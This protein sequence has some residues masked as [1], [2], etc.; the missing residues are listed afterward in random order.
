MKIYTELLKTIK[1]TVTNLAKG[2][3]GEQGVVSGWSWNS[4]KPIVDDDVISRKGSSEYKLMIKDPSVGPAVSTK[5]YGVLAK[6]YQIT[7]CAGE[8][9]ANYEQ[10][11]Q[12]ADFVEMIFTK[13]PGTLTD[14]LKEILRDCIQWGG[15]IGE[16][17]W[18]WDKELSFI[19]LTNIKIKDPLL[20]DTEQ[21]DYGNVT[22]LLLTVK[23]GKVEVDQAKFIRVVYNAV[24]GEAWGESDLRG[25][26]LYWV[27]KSKLIRW[28]A[29]YLEKFAMPTAKGSF[30][31]GTPKTA[32]DDLLKVLS[33]IQQETA[34]VIP[35][36]V[37]VELM[38][39][40]GKTSSEF[41]QA[42]DYF[43]KQITKSIL[44]QTLATE[45]N[46]KTGSLAQAKVH[47]DTL[48]SYITDLK[49]MIE[50]VMDEQVIR[51]IVDYNF[52]DRFYPNFILPLDEKDI[53][54][55]AAI[56]YQLTTCGQVNIGE[57][58]IREFLG[59]PEMEDGSEVQ[60][61][62]VNPQDTKPPARTPKNKTQPTPRESE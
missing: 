49:L 14:R 56:I 41:G 42:L 51:D 8:D 60:T 59:L 50:S 22:K 58:W 38:E 19:L 36:N 12:Q 18:E 33:S 23:G 24:H 44:G 54:L 15:S 27:I 5:I 13:M 55:L 62:I 40:A 25:A 17:L 16:K 28:W 29:A 31:P 52:V 34:I 10:A 35:D 47:Q 2:I 1:R 4:A 48:I 30:A 57:S 6:G 46:S 11:K 37:Q 32:Q 21:D 20:Y 26:Y 45:Q 3:I 61:T 9:D 7:P 53:Q 43:D 39:A